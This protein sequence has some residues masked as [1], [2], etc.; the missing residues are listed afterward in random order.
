M[1]PVDDS[2]RCISELFM[3]D[4][5]NAAPLC[6]AIGPLGILKKQIHKQPLTV[7]DYQVLTD[8]R[9]EQSANRKCAALIE[10]RSLDMCVYT[11]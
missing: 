1:A 10:D 2:L 9:E 8:R 6:V 3:S 7:H 11:N 4:P 5:E